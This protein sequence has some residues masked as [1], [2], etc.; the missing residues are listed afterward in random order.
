LGGGSQGAEARES[1]KCEKDWQFFHILNLA[2]W[3]EW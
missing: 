3:R 1:A 2:H